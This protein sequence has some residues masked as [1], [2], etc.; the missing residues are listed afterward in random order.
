[1][2]LVQLNIHMQKNE[3][4]SFTLIL[5]KINSKWIVDLNIRAKVI[6]LLQENIAINLWEFELGKT[7]LDMT[8]KIQAIK[9]KSR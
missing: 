9:G 3:V 8:P 7:S 6:I 5:Q 2:A 4:G 1:M